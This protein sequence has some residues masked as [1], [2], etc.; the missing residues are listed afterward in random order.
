M[1]WRGLV[2]EPFHLAVR[3]NN[4]QTH[5]SIYGQKRL[6]ASDLFAVPQ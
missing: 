5:L 2:L 3:V 6:V 4:V 1:D